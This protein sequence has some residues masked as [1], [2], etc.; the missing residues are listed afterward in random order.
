MTAQQLSIELLLKHAKDK[1]NKIL[2]NVV[3]GKTTFAMSKIFQ[4]IVVIFIAAYD[5]AT[6]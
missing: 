4:S 1:E 6:W 3:T 2:G 5:S